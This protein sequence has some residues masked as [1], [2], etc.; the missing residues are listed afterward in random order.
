[1][2]SLV[3]KIITYVLN[4]VVRLVS[5]LYKKNTSIWKTKNSINE[6]NLIKF[7]NIY[8]NRKG[9][10]NSNW[11]LNVYDKKKSNERTDML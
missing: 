4:S 11:R 1:M 7:C 2:H 9:T 10:K 5:L 8:F 3:N 6:E